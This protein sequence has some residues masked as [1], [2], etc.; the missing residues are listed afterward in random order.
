MATLTKVFKAVSGVVGEVIVAGTGILAIYGV[1]WLSGAKSGA[2]VGEL[3]DKAM[4]KAMDKE[5]ISK[6]GGG[7]TEETLTEEDNET[8]PPIEVVQNQPED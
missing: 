7:E 5:I 1:G 4:D 3:I 2:K 6:P 8:V